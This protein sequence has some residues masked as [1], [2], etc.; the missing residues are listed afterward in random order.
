MRPFV[1]GA[2]PALS[3][4]RPAGGPCPPC[5]GWERDLAVGA[6]LEVFDG[7][8]PAQSGRADRAHAEDVLAD[9]D[10]HPLR[11]AAGAPAVT[12]ELADEAVGAADGMESDHHLAVVV[13]D[14]P[15]ERQEHPHD[16]AARALGAAPPP[17]AGLP[18]GI[19]RL[20]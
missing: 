11:R 14:L 6:E 18:A 7:G 12:V 9:P 13:V 20:L 10:Q 1:G 8:R 5:M 19:C 17:L 3:C 16:L 2:R 15:F 4:C